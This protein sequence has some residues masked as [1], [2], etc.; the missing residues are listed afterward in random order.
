MQESFQASYANLFEFQ[1]SIDELVSKSC[2]S[3]SIAKPAAKALFSCDENRGEI[4]GMHEVRNNLPK[5]LRAGLPLVLV[6][7]SFSASS[8]MGFSLS[9]GGTAGYE[10][11]SYRDDPTKLDGG[12][13]AEG[14]AY[15]QASFKGPQFG[16][17][18]QFGVYRLDDLEGL[19]GV[20][21]MKSQ[22]TKSAE[23]EGYST[24]GKFNYLDATLGLGVRMWLGQSLS[25]SALAGFSQSLSNDMSSIKKKTAGDESLGEVVFK[26]EKH[27]KT[28][29]KLGIAFT[30]A[31]N[32]LLLGLD[33]RLGSGC[34]D[35]SSSTTSL[36]SRAY[37]TRS[38]NL[39]V[40]WMMGQ[41]NDQMISSP[42][43]QNLK[44]V[45]PRRQPL[46][47]APRAPVLEDTNDE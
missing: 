28:T 36:Q 32:G 27:K 29:L 39:T 22:L 17:A 19:V 15:E 18:G 13:V 35:C 31:I 8:A 25:A 11:L 26:I 2:A 10:V 37:L 21:L 44:K 23:S 5:L 9:A 24:D 42:P 4:P 3:L 16:I 46:K 7:S 45:V 34:F 14:D 40:A 38:G 6:M 30:P 43:I 12:S 41:Q 33:F 1:V 20:E 47:R